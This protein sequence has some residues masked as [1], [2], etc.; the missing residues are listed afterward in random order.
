MD[1][2]GGV[3]LAAPFGVPPLQRWYLLLKK[4]IRPKTSPFLIHVLKPKNR[5]KCMRLVCQFGTIAADQLATCK[6]TQCKM[7]NIR[8]MNHG[9]KSKQ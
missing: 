8:N 4:V 7:P 6:L 9:K 2:E 1:G 5:Y 3:G